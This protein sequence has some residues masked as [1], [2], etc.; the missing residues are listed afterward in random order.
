MDEH[1]IRVRGDVS[2]VESMMAKRELECIWWAVLSW[3]GIVVTILCLGILVAWINVIEA[4]C[5]SRVVSIWSWGIVGVGIGILVLGVLVLVVAACI[6][7]WQEAE[8]GWRYWRCRLLEMREMLEEELVVVRERREEEKR[9][10]DTI[11]R[12]ENSYN[13]GRFY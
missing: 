3:V 7:G 6:F 1:V 10:M 2:H 11:K 9:R 12:I 4:M 13:T 8:E 5:L